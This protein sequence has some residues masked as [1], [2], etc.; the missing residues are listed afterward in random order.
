[1][2]RLITLSLLVALSSFFLCVPVASADE[3]FGLKNLAVTFEEKGGSEAT[4]AGSHPYAMTTVID[5]NTTVDPELGEIPIDAA[6]DLKI[7]LPPGLVA[8]PGSQ[9]TCPAAVFLASTDPINPPCPDETVLGATTV[10]VGTTQPD[11]FTLP[12]YNMDA[13]RG[14]VLQLG[15]IALGVPVTF[16]VGLSS[17]P[18]YSGLVSITNIPQALNFYGSETTIWGNPAD[19][20]HDAER[21]NCLISAGADTCPVSGSGKPFLTLPRSCSGPLVTSFRARSWQNPG[22]WLSQTVQST[23]IDDCQ[24]LSFGPTIEATP[25]SDRVSSPSGLA[26]D[27]DI[28]DEGLTSPNGRAKSDIEK[29]EVTLPPGITLNPSQAEGLAACSEADLAR[30]GPATEFGAGCPAASKVGAV[31]AESPLLE[32]EIFHGSLFVAE[33]FANRFGSLIAVY[34]VVKSPERGIAIKLAGKVE[35]TEGT[36]PEAGRLRSSFGGAGVNALPQVPLSHVRLRLREGGRSPLI[37]PPACGNYETKG[38]FVPYANPAAIFPAASNFQISRG[39]DGGGCPSSAPF[40]PG[41]NAGSLS[42]DAGSYSPFTMRL[43]RR[44]GDQDMTRFDAVLPSG[45]TG[46]LAGVSKCP[47]AGIA[48]AKAKAGKAEL[49][50]PSCPANSEI[51]DTLAGAGVGSQLTYVPGKLYLAGP[52]GGAPLSVVAIT[53]AVAGPFDVGTVVVRE[54]LNLDPVTAQVKV[55]GAHSDSIPHTLAGIPLTLRDLRVHVNRDRFVLNPTSCEAKRIGATLF[56]GGTVFSPAAGFPVALTS[57]FQAAD[58]AALGFRPRLNLRL[59]GGTKR[60]S[61]PALHAVYRPRPGDANLRR[62]SLT[63]PRSE[64]VEN[65]H[66]RTICTRVQ[67]AA[68]SCPKGAIYGR[69][70][71]FSPLLDEPLEGPVYL[72]SSNNLLPDAVFDLHGIVDVEVAVRI[73]SVKGRLRATVPNAPD[74]PVSRVVVKM[75]GGDKGLFV[76]SRNICAH[77]Y[78][79]RLLLHAQNNRRAALRPLLRGQCKTRKRKIKHAK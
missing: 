40:A 51:G 47:D 14:A 79:A 33:P 42:N 39:L 41:F 49:A 57:R 16:E 17:S 15:F 52:F 55:D 74:V 75:Q 28:S 10:I 59:R 38:L 73:D 7:E 34:M 46:K 60:G 9:Q 58:C 29:V 18:P 53:P 35:P 25:S 32:G 27:L 12:V 6:K 43:T 68:D 64:F 77:R 69:V 23:A 71:A 2:R 19:S 63:F 62:L 20:S 11:E 78:A 66:F 31:E 30:E 44:D 54:A 5:V 13:P 45:V 37:T 4:Q 48:A 67:F 1:M 24:S 76:N 21:G 56:G 50:S 26:F 72:R 65:A 8:D 3:G 70:K 61:H 22:A 36:G